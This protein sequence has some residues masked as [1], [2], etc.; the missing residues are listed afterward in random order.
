MYNF[1][2]Q[3]TRVKLDIYKILF[4]YNYQILFIEII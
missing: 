4:L 3:S 1:F 2:F